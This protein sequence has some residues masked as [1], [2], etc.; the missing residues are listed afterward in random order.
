MSFGGRRDYWKQ[1]FGSGKRVSRCDWLER[2]G[3]N[4]VGRLRQGGDSHCDPERNRNTT[5][6]CGYGRGAS[7]FC[8]FRQRGIYTWVV[9]EPLVLAKLCVPGSVSIVTD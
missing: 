7:R 3:S 2:I 1:C 6:I 4:Q 8:L 5:T 9:V